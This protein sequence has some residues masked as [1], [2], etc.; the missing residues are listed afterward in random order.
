MTSGGSEG[1]SGDHGTASCTSLVTSSEAF[2]HS[3][4]CPDWASLYARHCAW[5][6]GPKDSNPCPLELPLRMG[7][8]KQ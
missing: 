1:L 3:C 8:D 6:G 4:N 7:A 5:A 2:S